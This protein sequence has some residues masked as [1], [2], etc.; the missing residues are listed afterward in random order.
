[1]RYK[2]S[3]EEL[4]SFLEKQGVEVLYWSV[5]DDGEFLGIICNGYK[6]N[7]AQQ[8][9]SADRCS[10]CHGTGKMIKSH[11]IEQYYENE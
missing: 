11:D 5:A 8:Q 9:D 1:M 6:P 3:K 4:N 7:L 10:L 2:M